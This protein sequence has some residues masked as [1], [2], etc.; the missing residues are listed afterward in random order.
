ME[1]GGQQSIGSQRVGHDRATNTKLLYLFLMVF[2]WGGKGEDGVGFKE[3]EE[4]GDKG[5]KVGTFP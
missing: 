4:K 3:E 2:S 1:P 5:K